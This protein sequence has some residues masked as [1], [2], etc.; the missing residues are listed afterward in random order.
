MNYSREILSHCLVGLKRRFLPPF[1]TR[2]AR[3]HCSGGNVIYGLRLPFRNSRSVNDPLEREAAEV[4][5]FL[6]IVLRQKEVVA[7]D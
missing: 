6:E 3:R 4:A 7:V 1:P 2:Q 5:L